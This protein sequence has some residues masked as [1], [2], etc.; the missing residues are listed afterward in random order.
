M[1]NKYKLIEILSVTAALWG[2]IAF[3]SRAVTASP[4]VPISEQLVQ[5]SGANDYFQQGMSFYQK[6]DFPSAEIAFRKAIEIDPKFAE[7]YANLGSILANQKKLADAIPAFKEAIRLQPNSP[8]F[9]YLL[10]ITLFQSNRLSESVEPLKKARD[11]LRSQGKNQD[12]DAI[13]QLLKE[14]GLK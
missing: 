7:A 8:A 13:D 9:H 11:L 6:G 10:G 5:N 3:Q 1:P 2:L 12:A 4:A 14:S